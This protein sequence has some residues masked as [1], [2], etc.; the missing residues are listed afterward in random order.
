MDHIDL[1]GEHTFMG[2]K[3]PISI[4]ARKSGSASRLAGHA[5]LVACGVQSLKHIGRPDEIYVWFDQMIFLRRD[6]GCETSTDV[7]GTNSG[8]TQRTKGCPP[9]A[10]HA[11]DADPYLSDLQA[12]LGRFQISIAELSS[13][14]AGWKVMCL[15][16]GDVIWHPLAFLTVKGTNKGSAG[17]YL[18]QEETW[19]L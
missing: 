8:A 16:S 14:Q 12:L 1:K 18:E 17:V 5:V 9:G 4:A 10:Q 6:S 19:M 13:D 2:R 15:I 11:C 7:F 3:S